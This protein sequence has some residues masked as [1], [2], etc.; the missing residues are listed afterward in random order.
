MAPANDGAPMSPLQPLPQKPTRAP[1]SSP[2]RRAGNGG[3]AGN[4]VKCTSLCLYLPRLLKKKRPAVQ[5]ATMSAEPTNA[6]KAKEQLPSAPRVSS[7]WPSSLPRAASAGA[8]GRTS[9]ASQLREASA[10]F[11]FSHWSRSHVRRVRRHRAALGPFSFPSSPASASSGTSTPKLPQG[12][13]G[14]DA[15]SP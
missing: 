15:R 10:S 9:S 4:G 7:W 5:P 8:A 6:Q 1:S 12:S 2:L 3:E 13:T 14:V 11:S